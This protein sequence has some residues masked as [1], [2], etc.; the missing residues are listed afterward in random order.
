ML[1]GF[2]T[3]NIFTAA[4]HAQQFANDQMEMAYAAIQEREKREYEKK[5]AKVRTKLEDVHAAYSKEKAK[6]QEMVKALNVF[7]TK[8]KEIYRKY[9]QV[10][11]Q[12]RRLEQ[13]YSELRRS[14]G[15]G[16]GGGNIIN[17]RSFSN[18]EL[19][20]DD[21]GPHFLDEDP[22]GDTTPRDSGRRRGSIG[23]N[24][25]RRSLRTH[26]PVPMRSLDSLNDSHGEVTT[27]A[28]EAPPVMNTNKIPSFGHNNNNNNNNNSDDRRRSSFGLNATKKPGSFAPGLAFGSKPQYNKVNP[29]ASKH[30]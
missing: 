2:E 22:F 26:S 30:F 23:N 18:E 5:Y 3:G 29:F 12:K 17:K 13:M 25:V 11:G 10:C 19:R 14:N 20:G 27:K 16:G 4:Y 15:G 24:P 28:M 21:G 1:R 6:R 7:K 8:Q 9:E